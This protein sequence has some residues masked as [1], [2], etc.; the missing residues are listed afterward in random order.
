MPSFEW[1]KIK[2]G[3]P[4]EIPKNSRNFPIIYYDDYIGSTKIQHSNN[5]HGLGSRSRV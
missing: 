4:K 5:G 1:L 3:E 2:E